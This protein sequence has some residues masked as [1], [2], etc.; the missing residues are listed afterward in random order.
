MSET[1]GIGIMGAGRWARQHVGA[2]QKT[3]GAKLVAMAARSP[4]TA[5]AAEAEFGVTCYTDYNQLL[6]RPDIDAIIVAAPNYL[7]YPLAKAALEAGK[8]T[9]VEKPMSFTIQECDDLIRI[10]RGKGKTLYV[11]HEF[12]QFSIWSE[13]KR[14]LSEGAIGQPLFGDIQ[15]WR[16]PYRS[17]A[18]GW[19]QDPAKVGNW[20]LEEPVHYFDLACWFFNQ[21]EPRSAYARGN[22]RTE[23]KAAVYENFSALV[24]FQNN[25]YVNITRVVTAY[26]FEIGMRFTGTEGVLKASWFGE[27]DVSL[28]PT[29]RLA[30]YRYEDKV[31]REVAITQ[32]TGHAFELAKQTA[33]FLE[34]IKTGQPAVTGEDGRRAVLLCNAA[35][36]SLQT[37]KVI[38]L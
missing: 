19:K 8:H 5:A 35:L 38:N 1:V 4:E 10:A 11:G 20:L 31:E 21:S 36:E 27:A 23:E 37:G 22:S 15:L 26:N 3:P 18:G 13:T 24:D 34:A 9:L 14:L 29:V 17:G 32:Q 28:N 7:H 25:S 2:I 30:T 33:A 6:A 16:Y 12:R